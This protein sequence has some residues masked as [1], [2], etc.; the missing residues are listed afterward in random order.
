[1]VPRSSPCAG[2]AWKSPASTGAPHRDEV[3]SRQGAARRD[4]DQGGFLFRCARF[5][6]HFLNIDNCTVEQ[7]FHAVVVNSVDTPVFQTGEVGSMPTGR[8]SPLKIR[9]SRSGSQAQPLKL[10]R[11][12][13]RLV[14]GRYRVRGPREAHGVASSTGRAVGWPA[15]PLPACARTWGRFLLLYLTNRFGVRVPGG[16]AT[17]DWPSQVWHPS[18]KRWS[19]RER[20]AGSNPASSAQSTQSHT[21]R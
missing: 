7:T 5:F 1:M 17:E 4:T 20:R 16:P 2:Q 14:S 21:G 10:N 18:R 13:T 15:H 19:A 11:M 3:M 12:S 6:D 9:L 8:S